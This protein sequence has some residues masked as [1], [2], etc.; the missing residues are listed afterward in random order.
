MPSEDTQFKTGNEGRKAGTKNVFSMGK[1]KEAFEAD[2]KK[3]DS[4]I[5]EYFFEQA[6][7]D[8]GAV[9]VALMRKI[10][11]DMKQV[12]VVRDIADMPEVT[13]D[14]FKR[15]VSTVPLKPNDG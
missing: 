2:E 4:N 8:G 1:F 3:Y 6:R 7:K 9:L 10:L 5:F 13:E 15:L 12:E 14:Y 11:P